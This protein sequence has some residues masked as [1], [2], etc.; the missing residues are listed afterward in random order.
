MAESPAR[1]RVNEQRGSRAHP[2]PRSA[3][4]A[5]SFPSSW[6]HSPSQQPRSRS[7]PAQAGQRLPRLLCSCRGRWRGRRPGL[8]RSRAPGSGRRRRL[9][10]IRKR[11]YQ[12]GGGGGSQGRHRHSSR[13]PGTRTPAPPAPTP[14]RPQRSHRAQSPGPTAGADPSWSAAVS[15]RPPRGDPRPGAP[16]PGGHPRGS[17]ALLQTHSLPPPSLGRGGRGPREEGAARPP[18]AAVSRYA[19]SREEDMALRTLR[20][21]G[22]RRRRRRCPRPRP[23]PGR[24]PSPSGRPPGPR[25]TPAG[26]PCAQ[27]RGGG[28]GGWSGGRLYVH[29]HTYTHNTT[30]RVDFL[31]SSSSC[32]SCRR[33]G[34]GVCLL[35]VAFAPLGRAGM[36]GILI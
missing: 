8:G 36:G 9:H 18:A 20:R 28:P 6:F 13:A 17:P 27:S 2:N 29:T 30:R 12:Q 23:Q 11:P 32:F 33:L 1:P 21:T 25:Q 5:A 15:P 26:R 4:A 7:L 14:P 3:A 31:R 10:M 34:F 35:V 19:T 16:R 22:S 24:A